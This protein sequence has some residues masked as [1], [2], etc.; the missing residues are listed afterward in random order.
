M[1]LNY[2]L[3]FILSAI[4]GFLFWNFFAGKH[5]GD[6]LER[7]FRPRIGQYRVH[8]HHWIWCGVLLIIF[9][10]IKVYNP[11]LLG[12]LIGSIIQGLRY[13]D[14]FICIYKDVDFEKIYSKFKK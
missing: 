5:E 13:K 2:I 14:R 3:Q 4:L 12:L 7:S 1:T 11:I 6:K 8:I 9:I 10:I